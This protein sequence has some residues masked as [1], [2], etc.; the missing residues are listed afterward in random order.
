LAEVREE[1]KYNF[2]FLVHLLVELN[3]HFLMPILTRVILED[4]SDLTHGNA[5]LSTKAPTENAI[6][7]ISWYLLVEVTVDLV[8]N[9]A[10]RV[11]KDNGWQN[12]EPAKC[13]YYQ[14]IDLDKVSFRKI[15]Y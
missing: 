12:N 4:F 3:A 11:G 15:T 8:L 7:I 2:E 6:K 5:E 9:V 10:L 1:L 14:N 13:P